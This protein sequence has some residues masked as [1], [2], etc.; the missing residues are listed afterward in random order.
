MDV[1]G[2]NTDE[3]LGT[4]RK[5]SEGDSTSDKTIVLAGADGWFSGAGAP[6]RVERGC[7]SCPQA[8]LKASAKACTVSKRF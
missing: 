5:F 6:V 2:G 1:V 7:G 3:M 4:V 8:R